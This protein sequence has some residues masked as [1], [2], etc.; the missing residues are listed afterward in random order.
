MQVRH[1][2]DLHQNQE[3]RLGFPEEMVVPHLPITELAR[4]IINQI[5]ADLRVATDLHIREADLRV[6]DLH[7]MA[8]VLRATD[9]HTMAAVLRVP[10]L[11]IMAAVL[12]DL[13]DSIRAGQELQRNR[14]PSKAR[15]L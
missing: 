13:V 14:L 10:D 5:R 12:N 8:A 3:V 1:R 15:N 9:L 2:T 6:T 7:T 4:T 11:L